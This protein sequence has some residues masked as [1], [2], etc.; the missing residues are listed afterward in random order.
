MDEVFSVD[1]LLKPLTIENEDSIYRQASVFH[2]AKTPQ[3]KKRRYPNESHFVPDKDGLSVY[4]TKYIKLKD[5]FI[6]IGLSYVKDTEVYKDH[7]HFKIFKFPVS[8]VKAIEGILGVLHSPVY[9]GNPAP[10]GSPNIFSHSLVVYENDPEI[11]MKLSDYCRDNNDSSFCDFNVHSI[12]EE[13][14]ELRDRLNDTPFHK[15]A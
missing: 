13:V 11:R 5:V 3:Q 15:V 2:L 4:W 6:I 14:K 1:Q 12:D 7:T 8:F 10:V 9:N